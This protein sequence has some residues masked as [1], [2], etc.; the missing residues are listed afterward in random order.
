MLVP[1][2]VVALTV[3]VAAS[4]GYKITGT[5]KG[6]RCVTIQECQ[7]LVLLV[8]NGAQVR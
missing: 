8:E 6:Q 4:N 2:F 1:R 5:P 7:H 3:A